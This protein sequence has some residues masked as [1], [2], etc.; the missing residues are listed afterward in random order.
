MARAEARK[1]IRRGGVRTWALLAVVLGN[2]AGLAFVVVTENETA[3]EAL[4][5][6]VAGAVGL[7]P[8]VALFV[9]GIATTAYVPREISDGTIL[10]AK[11]LVPRRLELFLGRLAAWFALGLTVAAA[12]IVP[13]LLVAV[14]SPQVGRSGIGVTLAS[15]GVCLVVPALTLC[16]VHAG[17]LVLKRGAY[18]VA[19]TLTLLLILPLTLT[20]GEAALSGALADLA[21]GL[22]RILI[23]PLVVTAMAVPEGEVGTWP[24][25]IRANLGLLAWVAVVGFLAYRRFCA[26]GYGDE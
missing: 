25:L 23:G 7:G 13:S 17:A 24:E 4:Q 22:G 14:F 5:L 9:L 8:A 2:A 19:V 12:C 21:R 6:T 1:L 16:L 18:I 11:T 3:R 10:T 20:L 15:V 26:E